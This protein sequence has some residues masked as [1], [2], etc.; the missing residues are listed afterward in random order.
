MKKLVTSTGDVTED[1]RNP[2]R[3]KTFLSKLEQGKL[4]T[5]QRQAVITLIEKKGKDRT[6]IKKWSPISLLNSTTSYLRRLL[7]LD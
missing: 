5:S 3:T 6:F 7:Q 2:K 1:P 4:S